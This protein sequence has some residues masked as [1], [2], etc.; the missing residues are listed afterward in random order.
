MKKRSV[1]EMKKQIR[2]LKL[3]R[4]SIPRTSV[5]GDDNHKSIDTHLRILE[6]CLKLD[7][8]EIEADCE[9]AY[10]DEDRNVLATYDWILKKIDDPLVDDDCPWVEKSL[11]KLKEAK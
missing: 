8:D 2:L 7:A 4:Q 10:D 5:F 6:K 11:R 9:F 3:Q 1:T